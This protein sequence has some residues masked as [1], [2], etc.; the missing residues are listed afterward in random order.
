[1]LFVVVCVEKQGSDGNIEEQINKMLHLICNYKQSDDMVMQSII[2]LMNLIISGI[3]IIIQ[4][5]DGII[6]TEVMEGL[7]WGGWDG[8]NDLK[9]DEAVNKMMDVCRN[10]INKK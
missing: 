9:K 10:L 1:L 7:F 4:G 2:M 8:I 6:C 3:Q 5:K